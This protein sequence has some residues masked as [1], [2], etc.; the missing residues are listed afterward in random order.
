MKKCYN[1]HEINEFYDNDNYMCKKC[2]DSGIKMRPPAAHGLSDGPG[3]S[4]NELVFDRPNMKK[5]IPLTLKRMEQDG[6]LTS[7]DTMRAAQLKYEESKSLPDEKID[8]QKGGHPL[9]GGDT[10]DER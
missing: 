4:V 5:D 10:N 1:C 7:P 8:Y 6:K 9:D 2:M 3:S